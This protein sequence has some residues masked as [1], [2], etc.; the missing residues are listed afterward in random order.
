MISSSNN[1]ISIKNINYNNVGKVK[2]IASFKSSS[3]TEHVDIYSYY[4]L[5]LN[6]S[7]RF[8]QIIGE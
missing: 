4:N 2:F 7:A 3:I 1:T 5:K 8:K 6:L